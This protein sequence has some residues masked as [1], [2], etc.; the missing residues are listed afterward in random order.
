M[1]I[2]RSKVDILGKKNSQIVMLDVAKM[3]S[4]T[5]AD[6]FEVSGSDSGALCL[7]ETHIIDTPI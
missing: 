2:V 5:V 7:I 1:H 6:V 4:N 3:C